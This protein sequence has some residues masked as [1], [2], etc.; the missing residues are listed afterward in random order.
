[1]TSLS[2]SDRRIPRETVLAAGVAATLA[3]A[4][5]WFGPP[6]SDFAAHLY[7]ST[8]FEDRG[9]GI[10]NNF[11]YAGRYSFVT[12]SLLYYPLAALIGIKL[13]AVL[14]IG[15]AALAFGVV[16]TREWG[17]DARWAIRSFAVVWAGVVLSGAFPFALGTALALLALWAIQTGRLGP[18]A[19]LTVLVLAASPVAFVLLA[20]VLAGIALARSSRGTELALPLAILCAVTSIELLL[21]RLFPAG[22]RYPFS[23]P[24]FAAACVFCG[25]GILL[26]WRVTTAG[27]LRW[28]YVV[29][30]IACTTAYLVPSGLGENIARIRYAAIPIAILTLSL[31]RW[32]PLWLALLAL[33]LAVAW[34]LTPLA[35]N[36]VKTSR[37][38]AATPA[39]WGPAIS[40]LQANLSPSYRVEAVDTVGHWPAAYL[41]A[42]GI[43]IARGWFRQDDFP[44]NDVLYSELTRTA[45]L[46]WLRSLGVRYVV[47]P[48]APLDYS[49]KEEGALI[50]GGRS[51]LVEVFRSAHTTVFEVPSPRS[52]VTGPGNPRVLNLGQTS[53]TL[54]LDRPGRYRVAINWS[55]YWSTAVGCLSRATDGTVQLTATRS[56]IVR[57]DLS[58]NAQGALAA[59]GGGSKPRCAG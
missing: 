40:F 20:V 13:L 56:G 17:A 32:R 47:L 12:Y 30:L 35:G 51:G 8:V 33:A 36:F 21:L 52:I 23:L 5:A 34:N 39:Y 46:G 24:E 9:F 4:L 58:V 16:A 15:T 42:A 50:A 37:D 11:W 28:T 57:L 44:R 7:Q 14:S 18:F 6:G 41:P 31:R 10:W 2:H 45:Y 59:L 29:Y 27:V 22:G 55:P 53:A 48:D 25:L 54:A 1:M 26:T 49:A 3:A 19:L 38:A 43:P